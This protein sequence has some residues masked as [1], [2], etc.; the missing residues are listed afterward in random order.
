LNRFLALAGL[1]SRRGAEEYIRH[2]RVT[3][4]GEL[5]MDLATNVAISDKVRVVGNVVRTQ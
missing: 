1:S 3:V 2:G 5:K 4:N